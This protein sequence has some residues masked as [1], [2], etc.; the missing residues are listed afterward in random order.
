MLAVRIVLF[1]LEQLHKVTA[2]KRINFLNF[3]TENSRETQGWP[4]PVLGIYCHYS[5]WPSSLSCKFHDV[6]EVINMGGVHDEGVSNATQ[7]SVIPK[8]AAASQSHKTPTSAAT[9]VSKLRIPTATSGIRT[10][11]AA[12]NHNRH[13]SQDNKVAVVE[14]QQNVTRQTTNRSEEKILVRQW[15]FNIVRINRR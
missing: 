15:Y 11:T 1:D 9:A 7:C 3:S 4:I 13:T 14:M 10:K 2:I 5:V 12:N 6:V 8:P